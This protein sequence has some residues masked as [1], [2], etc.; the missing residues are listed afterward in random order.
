[1]SSPTKPTNEELAIPGRHYCEVAVSCI[2]CPVSIETPQ[3]INATIDLRVKVT[4]RNFT[5]DLND[6][7]SDAY[8]NFVQVFKSQVRGE[9]A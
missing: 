2:I 6:K 7:S 5:D 8:K 3:K 9:E 4:N 1:M